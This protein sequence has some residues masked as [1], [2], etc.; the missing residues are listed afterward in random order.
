MP[1]LVLC[2]KKRDLWQLLV[3]KCISGKLSGFPVMGGY[4]VG[5]VTIQLGD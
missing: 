4:P 3:I 1:R 5:Y 2:S